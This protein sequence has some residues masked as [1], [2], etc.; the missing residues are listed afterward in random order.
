MRSPCN[1]MKLKR[2]IR[3]IGLVLFISLACIL[4]IPMTFSRKDDVPKYLIEQ[5]DPKENDDALNDD[6]AHY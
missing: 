2:L 1:I 5:I 6:I 4:P 3:L